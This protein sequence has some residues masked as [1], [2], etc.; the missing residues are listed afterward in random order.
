M[1]LRG[2]DA[3]TDVEGSASIRDLLPQRDGLFVAVVAFSAAMNLLLLTG[4]VYMVQVYGRVLPGGSVP[5]LAAL[6]LL[7]AFLFG[8]L[9]LLDSARARI[10]ARIGARLRDRLEPRVMAS[11]LDR[12]GRCPGDP[13]AAGA[14][15][16]LE[17]LHRYFA[18]AAPLALADLPWT[19]L[20]LVAATALHPLLGLAALG[21]TVMAVTLA[22][23]QQHALRSPMAAAAAA[24]AQAARLS[25]SLRAEAEAVRAL[26]LAPPALA[27]WRAARQVAMGRA[28]A[29]ADRAARFQ[30]LSRTLRLMLQSA[31]LGLGA[32][33]VLRGALDG[34]AMMAASVL[35]GRALAP[36]EGAIGHWPLA[37]RARSARARLHRLLVEEPGR[38]VPMALPRPAARLEV[39]GLRLARP[40]GGPPL[41]DGLSFRLE[42]GQA[43]GVIGPSGAGKTALARALAGI[44]PPSDGSIRL[45]DATLD[46]YP[47]ATLAALLGYLPQRVTLLDGSIAENIA[48]LAP[49]A[50]PAGIAAAARAA[51]AH[52]MVLRLPQGYDTRVTA[53]GDALSGGQVQRIGLARA[54]H[55]GPVM[56]LLDEP[57]AH[58]DAEGAEALNAALRAH[59][60]GGGIAVVMTHRP[61][62]IRDCELILALAG[63]RQRAFGP[64]AQ[65]L[66]EI[67]GP[68]PGGLRVVGGEGRA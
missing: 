32:W 14:E 54:L 11:A 51:G 64:R 2:D 65:V 20:F 48:R 58:L 21:G 47:E 63:G 22:W 50:D 40:G 29:G 39:S 46:R 45:D 60:A 15:E 13:L 3:G 26:G 36:V 5:T 41:L 1:R 67:F 59:K 30:A 9:S 42:P 6:S 23:G 68:G 7:A 25:A 49:G 53:P 37:E 27:R 17:S 10:V 34:G 4:P 19:P 33:L 56:L 66:R 44:W 31:V 16:D 8:L 55:G 52:E 62:A 18:S 61:A 38:P 12:A 57:S 43:L 24:A 35:T 28:L